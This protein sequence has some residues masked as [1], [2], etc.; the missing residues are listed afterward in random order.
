MPFA[1][2]LPL[3]V[4]TS[5][6]QN[7]IERPRTV[8]QPSPTMSSRTTAPRYWSCMSMVTKAWR[9]SYPDPMEGTTT[10]STKAAMA[11][12]CTT[13]AGWVSSARHGRR[14]RQ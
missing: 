1:T 14:M 2:G 9:S 11:P 5:A 12:P 3:A 13:P 7:T 4:T 6:S 10:E 8:T